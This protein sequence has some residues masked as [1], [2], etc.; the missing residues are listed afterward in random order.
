MWVKSRWHLK[1]M[2]QCN[3]TKLA[4]NHLGVGK[5]IQ[6][7]SQGCCWQRSKQAGEQANKN[8]MKFSRVQMVH[9]VKEPGRQSCGLPTVAVPALLWGFQHCRGTDL[10]S[11]VW[12]WIKDILIPPYNPTK[13]SMD[14]SYLCTFYRANKLTCFFQST[15]TQVKFQTVAV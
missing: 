2:M 12:P 15:R 6:S 14:C 11:P 4:Y 13:F 3:H 5:E 8:L 1:N 10:S 7:E 9:K